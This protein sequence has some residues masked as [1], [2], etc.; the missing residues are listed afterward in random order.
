MPVEPGLFSTQTGDLALPPAAEASCPGHCSFQ[1][2]SA[3]APGKLGLANLGSLG[4]AFGDK[5]KES[6][7]TSVR[8]LIL[9][10]GKVSHSMGV[11]WPTDF[12]IICKQRDSKEQKNKSGLK[13]WRV[14]SVTL[15]VST[16][17]DFCFQEN[18]K[19][20]KNVNS[21][22]RVLWDLGTRLKFKGYK[23]HIIV[24]VFSEKLSADKPRI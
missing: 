7:G 14:S 15:S 16:G 19:P 4:S 21:S 9:A 2:G 23:E 18:E 24:L 6:Q 20:Y 5:N 8:E 10:W 1:A 11:I 12:W 22:Y 17:R 13:A 3:G